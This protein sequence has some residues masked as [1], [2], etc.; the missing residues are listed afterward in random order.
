MD[1]KGAEAMI[2]V[3]LALLLSGCVSQAEF[4]AYKDD[5]YSLMAKSAELHYLAAEVAKD[6]NERLMAIERNHNARSY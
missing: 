3:M 1:T 4:Q 2:L 6:H 5:Q